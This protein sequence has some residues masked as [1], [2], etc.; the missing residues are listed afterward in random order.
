[1]VCLT[2]YDEAI[3]SLGLRVRSMNLDLK[4]VPGTLFFNNF[5]TKVD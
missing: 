1:M 3:V 5:Q 4:V 2:H